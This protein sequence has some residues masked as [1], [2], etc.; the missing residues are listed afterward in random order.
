M[1]KIGV[2]FVVVE[3]DSGNIGNSLDP[4]LPYPNLNPNLSPNP[5]LC[6]VD[7]N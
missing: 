3:A 7:P 5:K 4:T 2:P 1:E 6:N